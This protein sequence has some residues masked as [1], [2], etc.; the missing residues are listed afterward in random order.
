LL[1][2][3]LLLQA[4][5]AD[6]SSVAGP[7]VYGGRFGAREAER[8]LW[9][10][11]FGP[12]PGEAAALAQLGLDG[13]VR[14]LT[15]P[16]KAKLTGP[17]PTDGDG[18]HIA[19]Y[20]AWGHDVLWWMD[21]MV[22]SNQ[23]LVERMTLIWHDWFATGDVGSQRLGIRQKN[24]FRK[25]ALGSFEQL[26]L[27]V[28][29]DPAMLLW[30][31]G[32]ENTKYAPNENYGRELME[33][34]TLGVSDGTAPYTEDDVREQAR[35]LTG[36][37]YDWDD[38]LGYTNFH[39]ESHLHDDRSKTI[40]GK[41]GN[42][43][44]RDS[45]RL[46]IGNPAHHDYLVEKLWS[47]FIPTPP[48]TQTRRALRHL[49]LT[50]DHAVGPVVEAI[51]KH[52]DL[53]TGQRLVKPPVVLFVGLLKARG[54]FIDTESWAWITDLAGQRP[55]EPPN[56]AGWDE[57]RWLDTSTVRGRWY[58]I[59]E[60]LNPDTADPDGHYDVTETVAAA[61]NKALTFWGNPTITPQ[62]RAKL[63]AYAQSVENVIQADWEE[64]AYRAL[65]QNGLRLLVANSPDMETC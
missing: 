51:L 22:R 49:Y 37:S 24:L 27:D 55:F 26:L 12:R 63:T 13:A 34:F 1:T 58:G 36:W 42:F 9:R 44:W 33:L 39:Y 57:T 4:E 50:N 31:S 7:P 35:A 41:T 60:V 15:N 61:V 20:D 64:R 18:N 59:A 5:G 62:T 16:P 52:P 2:A 17:A 30:L 53:Y 54:R 8:L 23:P 29:I 3:G 43:D 19:P 11:G 46:C 28:T 56:V 47:Y 65:R 40:F 14:S 45:C 48:S 32:A 25:R 21:R 10:A 6:K 38:N